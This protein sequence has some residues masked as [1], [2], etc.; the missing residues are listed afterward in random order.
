[1]GE[2]A[3]T[4]HASD[5]HHDGKLWHFNARIHEEILQHLAAAQDLAERHRHLL[6]GG[7]DETESASPLAASAPEVAAP[8]VLPV[9]PKL[10]RAKV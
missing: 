6:G 10:Y 2:G 3:C 9:V 7:P 4:S 5:A 1:M 8:P